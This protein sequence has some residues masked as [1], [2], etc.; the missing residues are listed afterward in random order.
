MK[1]VFTFALVVLLGVFAFNAEASSN[2]RLNEAAVDEMFAQAEPVDFLAM[3]TMA[4][5]AGASPSSHAMLQQQKQPAVA[6]VLAWFLGPLGIHRAYLGTSTGTLIGYILTLGG[7]GIVAFVDWVVLLI[8]VVE[9]D[10]SKY[11]D[12][13][14]FFM[15]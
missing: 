8:A 1:K 5:L 13:P 7:C 15:W 12:N 3:N 11:V 4:P 14:R 10:I 6:F 2:Y 9:D